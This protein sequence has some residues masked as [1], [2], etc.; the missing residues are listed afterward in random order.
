MHWITGPLGGGE[1]VPC[2]ADWSVQAEKEVVPSTSSFPLNSGPGSPERKGPR[3]LYLQKYAARCPLHSGRS[4]ME[5]GGR[6]AAERGTRKGGRPREA[7]LVPRLCPADPDAAPRPLP[8]GA[9]ARGPGSGSAGGY[10]AKPKALPAA[11]AGLRARS[12]RPL[13]V[14][15]RLPRQR[16]PRPGRRG[17]FRAPPPT[18]APLSQPPRSRGG[19]GRCLP[20]ASG[21]PASG[22]PERGWET[23]G[24]G[25]A[26]RGSWAEEGRQ[27]LGRVYY[28]FNGM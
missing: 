19:S 5:A 1:F 10:R 27:R 17:R 11:A 23:A 26:V 7:W 3:L 8:G 6:G 4:T 16:R 20:G 18:G 2:V 28:L 25:Q 22:V 24:A 21:A 9:G 15:A 12:G 14:G 13:C